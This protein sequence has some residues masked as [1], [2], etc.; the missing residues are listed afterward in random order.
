MEQEEGG[1]SESSYSLDSHST[2][3]SKT[4]SYTTGGDV[5]GRS[6]RRRHGYDDEEDQHYNGNRNLANS[7]L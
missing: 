7:I 4:N 3:W 5:K 1:N 6:K 2:S